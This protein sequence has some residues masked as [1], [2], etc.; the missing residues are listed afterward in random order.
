VFE[1]VQRRIERPLWNLNY[2][3]RYLLQALRDRM[4]VNRPKRDNLQN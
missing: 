4:A 1:P 3:A 2:A